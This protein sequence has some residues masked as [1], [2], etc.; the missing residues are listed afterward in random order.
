MTAQDRQAQ[1][2]DGEGKKVVCDGDHDDNAAD[3]PI[4]PKWPPALIRFIELFN[5]GEFWES[6]EVL[7][8]PWRVNRSD[9]YQ[10]LIIYA[11]AFVHAQRG[12]PVGIRKQLAKVPGKL[13]QYRPHY[14]GIDIDEIFHHG[15]ACTKTVLAHPELQGPALTATVPYPQLTLDPRLVRGDEP[16]FDDI[17]EQQH[18]VE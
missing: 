5:A 6:H 17:V 3:R 11:S 18:S 1:P 9:F 14:M 8:T 13:E 7:E 16:E 15:R 12:N 10:G 2:V 4:L